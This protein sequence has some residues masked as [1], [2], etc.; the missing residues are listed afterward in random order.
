M[1][2]PTAIRRREIVDAAIRI[3]VDR[4]SRHFTAKNIAAE[5]DLTP[6]AIFRH[7]ETMDDIVEGIIGRMDDVLFS[8][9]VTDDPDPLRRLENFVQG[10]IRELVDH[11]SISRMLLSDHLRQVAGPDRQ[12]KVD[13][14]R[15]RSRTFVRDCLQEADA[16]GLLRGPA[17]PDEALV[18]VMGTIFALAHSSTRVHADLDIGELGRRSWRV[19]DQAFRGHLQ[20]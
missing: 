11:P 17:G 13:E 16:Q 20:T 5:V 7:F 1:R 8:G 9:I 4:G 14:F 3:L 15:E 10:R 12:H 19:L 2:K 6:G 18:L